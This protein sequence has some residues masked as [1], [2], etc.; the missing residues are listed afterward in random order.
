MK[1]TRFNFELVDAT[2]EQI[3]EAIKIVTG[4]GDSLVSFNVTSGPDGPTYRRT[5]NPTGEKGSRGSG[6]FLY[7]ESDPAETQ[8]K[9]DPALEP[10]E[11]VQRV[12][13]LPNTKNIESPDT[14]A[15][16]DGE[17]KPSNLKKYL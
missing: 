17:V 12:D 15:K 11:E 9:N 1:K 6:R 3:A 13:I 7:G 16:K 8:L 4:F 10:A 5:N 14:P 2:P